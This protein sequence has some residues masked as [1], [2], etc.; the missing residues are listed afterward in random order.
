V[1]LA[2]AAST[3]LVGIWLA[4]GGAAIGLGGAVFVLD[5]APARAQA[6]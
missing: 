6:V 1:W 5:H 2:A 3:T 4:I